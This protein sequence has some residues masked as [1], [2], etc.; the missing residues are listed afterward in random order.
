MTQLEEVAQLLRS[1]RPTAVNLF[2]AISLNAQ[3]RLRDYRFSRKLKQVLLK[4]AQ[5][6][7]AEDL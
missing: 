1:T 4:T 6:I 7:N 3:N 5:M 2:W